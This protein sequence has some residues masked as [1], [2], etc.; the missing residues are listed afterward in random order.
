MRGY[1]CGLFDALDCADVVTIDNC[2]L[3]S[4]YEEHSPARR[5]ISLANEEKLVIEDQSILIVGGRSTFKDADG[6]DR[7]LHFTVHR[8]LQE[9]DLLAYAT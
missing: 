7:N 8:L 2:E 4:C 1:S 3:G 6:R 5:C 9:D